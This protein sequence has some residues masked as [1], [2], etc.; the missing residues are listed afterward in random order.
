M[1]I[2]YNRFWGIYYII[3]LFYLF[4]SIFVYANLTTLGDTERYLTASI[5]L[6]P[7]I[8]FNSTAQMDFVCGIIGKLLGGNNILSNFPF[9]LISFYMIKWSIEQLQF[10]NKIPNKLL[11]FILSLPNFCIWTSIASKETI[12]LVFSSILGVLVVNFL[13]GD[14]T[15]R[16]RDLFAL[17]LCLVYKPQYSP[18]I[19]EGLICII[20]IKKYL[21]KYNTRVAFIFFVIVAN[22]S[23]L[24]A[25]RDTVNKYA[26]IL[27][28]HFIS[29]EA[30]S[31]KNEN[32]WTY[33]DDFFIH[34]PM[35]I[36]EAFIGPTPQEMISKPTH[37]LAG[38][39]SIVLICLLF[40]FCHQPICKFLARLRFNMMFFISY[41][42]IFIGICLLHYPFGIFNAGSAIRYRT[43]FIYMF[44]LLSFHIYTYYRPRIQKK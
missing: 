39:E 27:P 7:T 35:G 44:I 24:Y 32:I 19:I 2:R 16:K 34:A 6:T 33:D 22:L 31:N 23:M 41:T 9:M 12:G 5:E 42:I 28:M 10:R 18:F 25:V 4:F 8:L 26:E 21:H 30:D 20:F 11:L 36:I 37:F 1:K 13:R 17:Y 29:A 43:N 3:R 38:I 14:Y 40:Y 15:I